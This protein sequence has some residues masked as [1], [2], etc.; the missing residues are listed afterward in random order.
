VFFGLVRV[1]VRV[2]LNGQTNFWERKKQQQQ[3]QKKTQR[4]T[5]SENNKTTVAMGI[6]ILLFYLYPARLQH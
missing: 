3:Q 2:T 5:I 1:R 6:T 4:K